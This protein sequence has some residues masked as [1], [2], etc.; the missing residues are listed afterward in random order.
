MIRPAV[1][2]RTTFEQHKHL[3]ALLLT[4]TL[5]F[6]FVTGL[7]LL[8]PTGLGPVL[9]P[10][11]ILLLGAYWVISL[12]G[13]LIFGVGQNHL[14]ERW[15]WFVLLLLVVTIVVAPTAAAI[16]ERQRTSPENYI[17]DG[18]I[19]VEE[20][21]RFFMAGKNPY[22]EDYTEPPMI[23]WP[24]EA[25]GPSSSPALF[26][27][28]YLP[29][30]FIVSGLADAALRPLL[31]WYDVR[32]LF[33]AALIGSIMLINRVT[34]TF[35]HRALLL[36]AS[37]FIP[38]TLP[39]LVEG[40][41]DVV[42][43]FLMLLTVFFLL[44]ERPLLAA[45]TLGLSCSV[46]QTAWFATPYILL[47]IS[48]EGKPVERIKRVVWPAVVFG[49][50]LGGLALP[51]AAMNPGAFIEDTFTY[52]SGRI[53]T[54][55][56]I[57][58]IGFGK[59]ILSIGVAKSAQEYFPFST[60]QL[61]VGLPILLITLWRQWRANTLSNA[62]IYSTLFL[63]TAGYF[64]RTFS[65]NYLGYLVGQLFLGFLVKEHPSEQ[66]PSALPGI[67][68]LEFMVIILFTD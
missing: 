8:S 47:Y 25:E 31:G 68:W 7:G 20:A 23:N 24:A 17:H 1:I 18:A 10:I 60:F 30:I 11:A 33:L 5:S 66:A 9:A 67:R 6:F 55:Y 22:E 54:S 44:R 14:Q 41:N 62:L 16:L 50:T 43:S 34:A 49:L 4:C 48:G 2:D 15:K 3:D 46:K 13:D 63:F 19:Q 39:Y 42:I 52:L 64:T 12:Y 21:G 26:H 58:G 53:P 65:E 57:Y 40:R 37:V 27:L 45:F 59:L 28:V 35:Q 36:I 32:L 56:P 51:W 61:G 38:L 29:L